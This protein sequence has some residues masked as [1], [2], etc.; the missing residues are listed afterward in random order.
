MSRHN[1]QTKGL[2]T[3]TMLPSPQTLS[4]TCEGKQTTLLKLKETVSSRAEKITP[5]HGCVGIA[6]LIPCSFFICEN[7]SVRVVAYL[8]EVI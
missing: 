2:N 7:G 3:N 4:L 1:R 5:F 8:V 6:I